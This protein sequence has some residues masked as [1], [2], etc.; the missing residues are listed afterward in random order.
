MSYPQA[1]WT[2]QGYALQTLHLIDV[3]R[4]RPFI[5]P[6]LEIVSVFPGKTLGG[7][8]LSYYGSGSVLEYSELIVI[9]AM[10]KYEDKFGGW[11]SHIYVDNADSVAGG[12]R[13][14]GLPKEL[15]EF[16]WEKG[17]RAG[18][19]VRQG[20]QLLCSLSYTDA[21]LPISTWWRQ[22][23]MGTAFSSQ[24]YNLLFFKSQ[25]ES[26]LKAMS[27]KLEIPAASPF[28][29]LNLGQPLLTV[30]CDQMNLVVGAPEAVGTTVTAREVEFSYP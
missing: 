2:L 9:P 1:P 17:D 20:D 26:Q 25:F 5:P 7:V 10:V 3:E 14:W 15:A 12:R 21:L 30:Y 22:P 16:T 18:V 27:G 24:N 4:S 28:S 13:I 23:L 19:T 11:V 29:Q 8:Y 6:E